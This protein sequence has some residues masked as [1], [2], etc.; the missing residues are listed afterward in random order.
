MRT[1]NFKLVMLLALLATEISWTGPSADY[2]RSAGVSVYNYP[3]GSGPASWQWGKQLFWEF[4]DTS[5]LS[6]N[7]READKLSLSGVAPVMSAVGWANSVKWGDTTLDTSIAFQWKDKAWVNYTNWSYSHYSLTA[8]GPDGNY[9]ATFDNPNNSFWIP[10]TIPLDSTDCPKG[11]KRCTYGDFAA[12]RIGRLC[13]KANLA[14]IYAADF[15]DGLPGGILTQYSF[16]PSILKAFEDS[17]GIKLPEGSVSVKSNAIYNLHMNKWV[18]FWGDAWGKF[19]ADVAK[20]IR[21]AGRVQPLISAQTAWDIPFRRMMAVDFRRYLRYMP[22]ENWF[23][24]IEMQGDNLRPM[25]S[26]GTQVGLFGTYASWEPSMPIGAKIN[27]ADQFLTEAMRLAK[28]PSTSEFRTQIQRSQYLLVGFTHLASR[29]GT[30]RR[31]AQAFEYGYYDKQSQVESRVTDFILAH[32]PRRPH[33]PGF[34]YSS[35]QVKSFEHERKGMYLVEQADSLWGVAPFGYF[36]T[37]AALDS[38]IPASKPTSWIVPSASRLSA[39][40]RTKLQS[41]APIL[42][43]DSA[44]KTS[45]IRAS[46]KGKAWGFWDHENALVVLVSNPDSTPISTTVSIA[47]L[48]AGTWSIAYLG[49]KDSLRTERVSSNL[50]MPMTIAAYDTRAYVLSRQLPT[51]ISPKRPEAQ[52]IPTKSLSSGIR[53][54]DVF[55]PSLNSLRNIQGRLILPR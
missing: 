39:T 12:D 40:E 49:L 7:R 47:G 37:D 32:F 25:K 28:M 41:I 11:M 20:I 3:V 14:G 23:F 43:A 16:H 24:A 19:Y 48:P 22:S 27:V 50:T 29:A 8:V 33:G 36:V 30:V 54:V 53:G 55:D 51:S 45:P 46:G 5:G 21:D 18:D 42:S 17:T 38:L 4:A 44:A 26:L 13:V 52:R 1:T 35:T 6:V 2:P 34:Y 10:F 15:V 31:A 9:L